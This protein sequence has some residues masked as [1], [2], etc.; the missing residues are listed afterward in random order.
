MKTTAASSLVGGP[1][2][3]FGGVFTLKR[4]SARPS[5]TRVAAAASDSAFDFG[6]RLFF[7]GTFFF[8][9]RVEG[10]NVSSSVAAEL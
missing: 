4:S 10:F 6:E 7:S 1:L 3:A 9:V 2:V 8:C 5:P